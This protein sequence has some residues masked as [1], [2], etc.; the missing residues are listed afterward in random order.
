[1]PSTSCFRNLVTLGFTAALAASCFAGSITSADLPVG[2]QFV[3][4]EWATVTASPRGFSHSTSGIWEGV[5]VQGGWVNDEIDTKNNEY[6]RIDF[7]KPKVVSEITLG[8][9][10]PLG[11]YLDGV[12]ET[13]VA[14]GL[15]MAR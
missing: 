3:D 1:M 5:G 4:L 9:L 6:I 11:T 14:S 15:A 8:F 12:F 13:A 10:F 7:T 2:Q